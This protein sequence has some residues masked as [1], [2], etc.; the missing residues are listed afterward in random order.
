MSFV[1]GSRRVRQHD[2]SHLFALFQITFIFCHLF[3]FSCYCI[4]FFCSSYWSRYKLRSYFFI[5]T[6]M[7]ITLAQ[8]CT[9]L[10][11][12]RVEQLALRHLVII[13]HWLHFLY[14]SHGFFRMAEGEKNSSYLSF[15]MDTKEKHFLKS[16][17]LTVLTLSSQSLAHTHTRACEIHTGDVRSIE[18]DYIACV[19]SI[20][21]KFNRHIHRCYIA[22]A[23]A[24]NTQNNKLKFDIYAILYLSNSVCSP[25]L[26]LIYQFLVF[27]SHQRDSISSSVFF[28]KKTSSSTSTQEKF[29][30]YSVK[31][32]GKGVKKTFHV[33]CSC[34]IPN[35]L[36]LLKHTIFGR[37]FRIPLNPSDSMGPETSPAYFSLQNNHLEVN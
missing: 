37:S 14:Y 8:L 13:T 24:H 12:T 19:F 4:Q 16:L 17:S 2:S 31:R 33:S 34:H 32:H 27:F 26:Y 15:G 9:L 20:S 3:L 18:I 29:D 11:E 36:E 25:L 23:R 6:D 30:R 35:T 5:E 28:R 1:V 7:R 10:P 22:F 21:R